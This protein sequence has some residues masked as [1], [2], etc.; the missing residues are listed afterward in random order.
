MENRVKLNLEKLK[1]KKDQNLLLA[2]SGGPDSMAMLYVLEKLSKDMGFKLYIAHVNH[3][4]RGELA[5]R[6]QL[7]VERIAKELSIPYFT[8][9]VDMVAYGKE[10]GM[11]SEE[12]GR[13]LRYGFFREVVSSLGGGYI[14]VAHNKNDQAETVLL[15]IIRGTGIEGLKAMELVNAD[16]IRP[17]INVERYE[18]EKYI[19]ENKIETMLDHTNLE[20]DYTRNKVRLEL[21]PYIEDNFNP[22]IIDSLCRL[23]DIAAGEIEIIDK[24]IEKKFNLIVKKVSSNS[25]IFR[26]NE[27]NNEDDP[28]KRK[29]IR[30]GIY[31]LLGDLNGIQEVNVGT[32]L[33]LFNKGDSG[34]AIDLPRNL[35]AKV[36]YEE[37]IITF[38]KSTIKNHSVYELEYG[39]NLITQL[40]IAIT[41]SLVDK[42]EVNFK[43]PNIRYFNRDKIVGRL[44]LRF[45]KD[46]DRFLPYGGVGS[47]KLKDY[48]IDKKISKDRRDLI[49]IIHDE[50]KIL[51]V[52]GFSIDERVKLNDNCSILKIEV[53]ECM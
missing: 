13:L 29:L 11:S 23:S 35:Q 32:I 42:E 18:I 51:W 34:K 10:F 45:R 26:G 5:R 52:V 28:V 50:E 17:L 2:V 43:N 44:S 53:K 15:R 19:L 21:I 16:I 48:F 1:L 3:G 31:N 46:G 22:N 37:L 9:D 38:K 8:K 36:N 47:K 6:D 49:P 33:Q 40:N 7:F 27:F 41:L 12:A 24:V 4:V 25:I 20:T 39:E 30:R 14:C